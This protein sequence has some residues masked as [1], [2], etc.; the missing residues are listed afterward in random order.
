MYIL[1]NGDCEY[2][3][4][5]TVE[6]TLKVNE[7]NFDKAWNTHICYILINYVS[8]SLLSLPIEI[9]IQ[10]IP[11]I[12]HEQSTESI[13]NRDFSQAKI[14]FDVEVFFITHIYRHSRNKS[15]N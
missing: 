12:Y 15:R 8:L 1:I 13:Q 5:S 3:R 9:H 2:D 10:G 6:C 14:L 11:E 7:M 4:K